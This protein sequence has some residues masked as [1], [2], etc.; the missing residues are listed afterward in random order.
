[1]ITVKRAPE[2]PNVPSI[3]ETGL[4]GHEVMSWFGLLGPAVTPSTEISKINS[5]IVKV[6]SQPDIIMKVNEQDGEVYSETLEQF[7]A[8]IQKEGLKW[9]K[10]MRDS[11]P[12]S[13]LSEP[14]V[15]RM[16]TR[17]SKPRAAPSRWGTRW[18][19]VARARAR[20]P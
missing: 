13:A 5:A 8:L 9:G 3:A 17:G 15:F 6:L 20:R 10:V 16:R 2:L 12:Q 14:W 4:P 7:S 11:G 1:M 18:E 19:P